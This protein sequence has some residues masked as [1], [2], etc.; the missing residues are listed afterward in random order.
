MVRSVW[1][2]VV[3]L[4]FVAASVS[5]IIVPTSHRLLTPS[6]ATRDLPNVFDNNKDTHAVLH[7]NPGQK[8]SIFVALPAEYCVQSVN[9]ISDLPA[10]LQQSVQV[11]YAADVNSHSP[12]L[13]YECSPNKTSTLCRP[14]CVATNSR[15][16]VVGTTVIWTLARAH[17]TGWT[18]I[19]DVVIEGWLLENHVVVKDKVADITLHKPYRDDSWQAEELESCTEQLWKLTDMSAG[20]F[21]LPPVSTTTRNVTF[22]FGKKYSVTKVGFIL[23]E[24]DETPSE[25]TLYFGGPKDLAKSLRIRDECTKE[26]DQTGLI[27]CKMTE[28]VDYPFENVS[29]DVKGIVK[30]HVYG[31]PFYYPQVGLVPSRKSGD[32]ARLQIKCFAFQCGG[33]PGTAENALVHPTHAQSCARYGR[34]VGCKNL[35]LLR[36]RIPVNGADQQKEDEGT[37]LVVNG[38]VM[39]DIASIMT[40]LEVVRASDELVVNVPRTHHYYGQYK[41]R[42]QTDDSVG[43]LVD[44]PRTNFT[45]NEFDQDLVFQRNY[46]AVFDEKP[47]ASQNGFIELPEDPQTS[48][49]KLVVSGYSLTKDVVLNATF[50]EGGQLAAMTGESYAQISHVEAFPRAEGSS[51]AWPVPAYRIDLQEAWPDVLDEEPITI[52]WRSQDK[53]ATLRS[54]TD[55]VRTIVLS[56]ARFGTVRGW[57][58]QR[59]AQLLDVRAYYLV[60]E[61]EASGTGS[62][63]LYLER[64]SCSAESKPEKIGEIDLPNDQCTTEGYSGVPQCLKTDSGYVIQYKIVAPSATDGYTLFMV[65]TDGTEKKPLA[66]SGG[67]EKDL[68][69]EIDGTAISLKVLSLKDASMEVGVTVHSKVI[70][71]SSVCRPVY[72][73]LHPGWAQD[74]KLESRLTNSTTIFT[75]PLPPDERN[76]SFEMEL[77]IQPSDPSTPPLETVRS[78]TIPDPRHY[79]LGLKT[80]AETTEITWPELP[81]AFRDLVDEFKVEVEGTVR[82][83]GTKNQ[84]KAP[85]VHDEMGDEVGHRIRLQEIPEIAQKSGHLID[86]EVRVQPLF[87]SSGESPTGGEVSHIR[88]AKGQLGQTLISFQGQEESRTVRVF[89]T[90]SQTASCLLERPFESIFDIQVTGEGNEKP[91]YLQDVQY[92]PLESSENGRLYSIKNLQP[93]RRYELKASVKYPTGDQDVMSDVGRF[94]TVDEV[95]VSPREVFASPGEAVSV[96]CTGAVG[97]KDQFQK[98]LEWKREDGTALPEGGRSFTVVRAETGPEWLETV[99]LLFDKIENGQA[100]VYGC[101]IRPSVNELLRK[102]LEPPTVKIGV[103]ELDLD[104]KSLEVQT[105]DSVTVKC[106]SGTPAHLVWTDPNSQVVQQVSDVGEEQV[107]VAEE[108]SGSNGGVVLK[109]HIP[110]ARIG[111]AGD[112][113]CQQDDKPS[114]RVFAL[115]LKEEIKVEVASDSSTKSGENL[116]LDCTAKL[117]IPEQQ[118]LWYHRDSNATPWK[119]IK[120]SSEV[121][122]DHFE[123]EGPSNTM[124]SHLRMVNSPKSN[125]YY[126]CVLNTS[127]DEEIHELPKTSATHLVTVEPVLNI[128]EIKTTES[129]EV[130]VQCNGYPAHATDRLQWAYVPVTENAKPIQIGDSGS[131]GAEEQDELAPLVRSTFRLGDSIPAT[132][133]GSSGP[134]MLASAEKIVARDAEDVP[135]TPERLEL[136]VTK[137][138]EEDLDA[139]LLPG[140]LVCQFR[141]PKAV[142][143]MENGYPA[144]AVKDQDRSAHEV[145]VQKSIPMQQLFESS[146]QTKGGETAIAG[147]GLAAVITAEE[148]EKGNGLSGITTSYL[149]TWFTIVLICLHHQFFF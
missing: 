113:T 5:I 39:P 58:W 140:S 115:R 144:Y 97:P 14:A 52:E 41:C 40:G 135:A 46:S 142:V 35:E 36:L 63:K 66:H 7:S 34:T 89:V 127:V 42:C 116:L 82:V 75:V 101:F 126:A 61:N 60:G 70:V 26:D 53:N 32:E 51:H 59:S 81:V 67:M 2:L 147:T 105:G 106:Q 43:S 146:P 31:M 96:N 22:Y 12:A 137:L 77:K 55:V 98:H 110:S 17:E 69:S 123:K 131:G 134:L 111:L 23:S 65:P 112:Y 74:A 83:C 11:G 143:S 122:T 138:A 10:N 15:D 79:N 129:K 76:L 6:I 64:S 37:T 100:N 86:Y 108:P 102:P 107:N 87:R 25:T 72:L 92:E 68:K 19:Y 30:L 104:I 84:L 118:I 9:I 128:G 120:E 91:E 28:V 33:D 125:G 4:S 124:T 114:K 99:S 93:G 95:S 38:T 121:T 78:L 45:A 136:I 56:P 57:V 90:P 141:R 71:D 50:K 24:K 16:C 8:A 44:S 13:T 21:R 132:W 103:S 62:I 48:Y 88:F 47:I 94:W 54:V 1:V 145:L 29:L 3:F 117:G 119:L 18:R 73:A 148:E 20:D 27:V 149:T 109:L 130:H 139:K 80:D 49:F 133:P 85:K